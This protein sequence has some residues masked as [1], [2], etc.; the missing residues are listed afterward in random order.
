MKI[1]I[2]KSALTEREFR[3]R[4]HLSALVSRMLRNRHGEDFAGTWLWNC[5]CF[6]FGPLSWSMLLDGL[7]LWDGIR[8]LSES[9]ARAD[10]ELRRAMAEIQD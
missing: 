1:R 9:M 7:L 3:L 6:P 4:A 2:R 5:T 10:E 8:P